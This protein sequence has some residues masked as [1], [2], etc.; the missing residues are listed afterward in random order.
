M[1]ILVG[2]DIGNYTF[3]ASAKTVTLTGLDVVLL[4]QLLMITNITTNSIIYQFNKTGYGGTINNNVITL[5]FNTTSMNDGDDLQI[6]ID[7]QNSGIQKTKIID[8]AS[9]DIIYVGEASIGGNVASAVWRI[10]K[11]NTTSTITSLLWAD[12]N[13]AYNKIWN[14]RATYTYS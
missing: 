6:F 12:G 8:E 1:K 7:Y 5:D 11:L 14:D 4:Q 3:D 13:A 10:S 9:T 2:T